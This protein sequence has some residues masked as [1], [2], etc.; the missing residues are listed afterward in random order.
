MF[1]NFKVRIINTN[2]NFYCD[3][4]KCWKLHDFFLKTS[5]NGNYLQNNDVSLSLFIFFCQEK[6]LTVKS[7]SAKNC[8]TSK[9]PIIAQRVCSKAIVQN[10]HFLLLILLILL[11][12]LLN[13][14]F[15]KLHCTLPWNGIFSIHASLAFWGTH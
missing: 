14:F 15:S 11:C 9:Q 3:R 10:V 1:F 13:S 5:S 4:H 6:A 12:F 7:E 2:R 8:T